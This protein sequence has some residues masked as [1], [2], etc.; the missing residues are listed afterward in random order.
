ML[1]LQLRLEL[2]PLL[3]PMLLLDLGLRLQLVIMLG[4]T[5]VLILRQM[6]RPV[7]QLVVALLVLVLVIVPTPLPMPKPK[8]MRVLLDQQSAE[9]PALELLVRQ[10]P[11]QQVP[12]HLHQQPIDLIKE[13]ILNLIPI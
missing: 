11:G 3:A 10:Q 6:P 7:Y 1:E 8:L 13:A 4:L 5:P 2:M 9:L 12:L